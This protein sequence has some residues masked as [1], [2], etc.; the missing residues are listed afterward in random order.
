MIVLALFGCFGLNPKAVPTQDLYIDNGEEK[1]FGSSLSFAVIGDTRPFSAKEASQG[2][3]AVPG[4]TEA[5][6]ADVSAA[7]TDDRIKFAMFMG[8]MVD[9]SS[10][11]AW[12]GF[13]KDWGLAISGSELPEPGKLRI[14]AIAAAGTHDR[15]GDD[16]LVG[17]GAAFPGVGADI[18]INRVASW[19]TFDQVVGD[20][21]WRF[22]VLDT[23]KAALGSRW[24]EQTA[25]LPKAMEGDYDAALVFMHAPVITLAKGVPSNAQ[26]APSE[27]L[28]IVED[29]ARLGAVKAVFGAGT[30]TNEVYLP[31]GKL[32]ELY[33]NAGCSGGPANLLPRWGHAAEG[34]FE[35]L[36]L[37]AIY[38]LTLMKQFDLWAEKKAFPEVV[39]E[40]ASAS[41]SY[42]GFPGEFDPRYFPV[43]G[44][45][46]VSLIGS[47][48]KV[49]FRM[50]QADNQLKDVYI[51]DMHPKEG[52]KTGR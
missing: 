13:S 10:T 4:A 49:T 23:D 43:A 17:Y 44:W 19:Y 34:G 41:G 45:W 1:T 21:R 51:A 46:Q 39:R 16:K 27:L 40:H 6:V 7:A 42:Q 31:S 38:D 9:S 12:K 28:S 52:W 36:K 32:G 8:N 37:E 50:L 3:A 47:S 35:D 48:M 18:G 33:V 22:V 25:W 24:D 29:V 5:I 26:E 30:G 15:I 14:R 20:T 2:W 11:S